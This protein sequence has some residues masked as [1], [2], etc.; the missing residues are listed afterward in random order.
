[1]QDAPPFESIMKGDSMRS[2]LRQ[3]LPICAALALV[4]TVACSKKET[5]PAQEAP[6]VNLAESD[7]F[8]QPV[9]PTEN[10]T[11]TSVVATVNGKPIIAQELERQ[12]G[13]I[14]NNYRNRMP[15]E[16]LAQLG[17]RFREQAI[18]QL[19]AKQL[20]TEAVDQAKIEATAE[21]L[22]EAKAK[23][24]AN[25]PPGMTLAELLKQRNISQEQFEKE[26]SEE[27]RINKL[28]EQ[29]TSGE[30]NVSVE[31]AKAFYD[32]N[33]TQFAQPETATARHILIGFDP[34]DSDEVKA[35]KKAKAE[36]VR[37]QLIAGGDFVA[38]AA[39]ES[40]DPGSKDTGGVYT[41]PR[42]QMVPAFEEAA[43]SQP[44][45]EIGPLVETRF[46]YHIIKV[47]ERKE[48]RTVPFDEVQTNLVQFLAMKKVQ[49][50]AQVYVEGLRSNATI[51][52]LIGTN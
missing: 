43:F 33:T 28:I 23:I 39:A 48:G 49:Q 51:N 12:M 26:F 40:D 15:P 50:A 7:I 16:Q 2:A 38:L 32:E 21:E 18:N 20:L 34:A 19:V 4:G 27:F 35:E 10:L 13:A 41:F 42:G 3:T 45:G 22:A 5:Q 1:M 24:E 47:D 14:I 6:Q 17:P 44:I 30:T 25:M 46:G 52:V 36:K 8:R 11:P 37:E 29:Q 31:E 9:P